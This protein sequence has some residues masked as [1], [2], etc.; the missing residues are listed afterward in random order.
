ME[1]DTENVAD[2]HMDDTIVSNVK[3]DTS[4]DVSFGFKLYLATDNYIYLR[5]DM[6][7]ST[8]LPDN[9]R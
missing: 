1:N 9:G 2:N 8:I 4:T 6:N 3:D 5:I 7:D